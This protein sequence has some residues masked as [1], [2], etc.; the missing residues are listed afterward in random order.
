MVAPCLATFL[1]SRKITSLAFQVYLSTWLLA[2][3]TQI[4]KWLTI[5]DLR[6]TKLWTPLE[7]EDQ[8][9]CPPPPS[10][11]I[12]NLV[13]NILAR[14]GSVLKWKTCTVFQCKQISGQ[15]HFGKCPSSCRSS[16][17]AFLNMI[18]NRFSIYQHD[19]RPIKKSTRTLQTILSGFEQSRLGLK[20]VCS[21]NF[22]NLPQKP[23]IPCLTMT[24]MTPTTSQLHLVP[25]RRS[26]LERITRPLT[27]FTGPSF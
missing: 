23:S 21:R 18:M 12:D 7:K 9:V 10:K 26:S 24:P 16:F 8:G 2:C 27:T 25:A 17:F 3:K 20:K 19:N 11:G 5:V 4:F 22:T 15:Q 14:L 6:L 13:P 1:G